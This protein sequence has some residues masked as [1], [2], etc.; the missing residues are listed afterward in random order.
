M[1]DPTHSLAATPDGGHPARGMSEQDQR[2]WDERYSKGEHVHGQA[3]GWL[4]ELDDEIPTDGRALDVAAGT[5][6]VAVWMGRRGL[7]VQAVDISPVGLALLREAAA[8]EGVKVTT[9]VVDLERVPLPE[10]PFDLIACF[11]YRQRELFP[12]IRER[13]TPSGV[14]V[15]ELPTIRNLERNSAPSKRWLS[16]SNELLHD[17][18]GLTVLYYREAWVGGRHVARMMARK[19]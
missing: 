19:G 5:G 15:V 6:R 12:V 18:A 9:R 2:K 13:L 17:L 4:R 8:D 10:G 1:A 14:V 11:H 16:E 7:D 3:P